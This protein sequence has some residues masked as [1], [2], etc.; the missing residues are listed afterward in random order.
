MNHVIEFLDNNNITYV[1][2]EH[3][4]VHTVEEAEKYAPH[5]PGMSCKNLFLKDK[6]TKTYILV[7]MPAEKR[8]NMKKLGEQMGGKKLTFASPEELSEKLGLTPGSVSPF[9]LLNDTAKQVS[10]Y[11]DN[12]VVNAE[13]VG[14]HP[15][16][17]TQTL[18]LSN[19]M[20]HAFFNAI[21]R[22]Y[23][24]ISIA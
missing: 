20:F 18:E 6:K 1:L 14:F 4:P 8:M 2:H 9:G 5:I 13:I 10:V 23:S 11:I 15:S 12:D 3:P 22:E 16:V 17:N 19:G 24:I 21:G 7:I